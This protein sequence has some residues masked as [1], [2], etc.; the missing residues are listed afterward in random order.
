MNAEKS[1]GTGAW[2]ARGSEAMAIF[3]GGG[4]GGVQG[5]LYGTEWRLRRIRQNTSAPMSRT[6]ATPQPTLIP[7]MLG[8][9][10]EVVGSADVVEP[11]LWPVVWLV[12]LGI[13]ASLARMVVIA[14]LVSVTGG[15]CVTTTVEVV[16]MVALAFN[17]LTRVSV[18]GPLV[19]LGK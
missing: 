11:G 16:E 2:W 17:T 5:S 10:K 19:L 1:M 3:R 14:V 9:G 7:M 8:V 15:L 18:R 12:V 13:D 4:P 6:A